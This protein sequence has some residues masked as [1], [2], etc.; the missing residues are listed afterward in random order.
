MDEAALGRIRGIALDVDGVLTDGTVWMDGAG[1]ELKRFSILDGT[2]LHWCRL[3][4]FEIAL[5][6]GRE[7][8]ATTAR[9]RELGIEAVYQGVRDKAGR[10]ETWAAE[11]GLG[12]DEVLYMGDDHIDLPAFDRVGVSVAPANA[13]DEVKDRADHVTRRAGGDGAVREAVR[14][15]LAST[16]RLEEATALYRARL[17]PRE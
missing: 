11:R 2:A 13:D 1:R 16:G 17:A 8:A 6:S 3:L 5:V 14:W 10:I 15:L 7:S 12:L 9:A 4:G